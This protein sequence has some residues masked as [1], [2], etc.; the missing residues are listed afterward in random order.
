MNF[1]LLSKFSLAVLSVV[2]AGLLTACV[3]GGTVPART[4]Q[5]NPDCRYVY[6]DKFGDQVQ[7]G[8]YVDIRFLGLPLKQ[9]STGHWYYQD[10]LGNRVY[11]SNHCK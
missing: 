8:K 4:Y 7:G 1:S 3:G 10:S 6:V 9:D 2:S 11:K 5:L